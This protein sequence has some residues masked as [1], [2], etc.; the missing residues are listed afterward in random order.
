MLESWT[1]NRSNDKA[2]NR[3]LRQ[4]GSSI[5]LQDGAKWATLGPN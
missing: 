5:P 4:N 1:P 2:M 3:A